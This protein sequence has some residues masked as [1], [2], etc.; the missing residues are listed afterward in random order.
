MIEPTEVL[1]G[2]I[3]AIPSKSYTHRAI[4]AASLSEGESRITSPLYAD[5]TLVTIRACETFGV[6]I[7][8]SERKLIVTGLSQLKTPSS[9]IDCGESAS[10]I[11]FLT[12][13]AA[14]VKGKTVL[15]GSEG[16]RRRPIA[17]LISALEKLGVK[18]SSNSGFPPVTVFGGGLKGGKTSLVGDV[19]SQFITGLLLACP[20]ARADSEIYLT[21][22]LESKPYV[23][24]TLAMLKKHGVEINASKSLRRYAVRGGQSYRSVDHNVPGDFSA[25]SFLLSAAAITKSEITVTGLAMDQPD[26]EIVNILHNMGAIVDVNEYSVKVSGKKLRGVEID[27][28]DIPDLVPIC[29]VLA[30]YSEGETRIFGAKRLRIK[31]S[32]RLNTISTELIKMG[33]RVLEDAEGMT[34]KGSCRLHGAVIN[35]HGDHRIAMACAVAGL[36]AE[37]KTEILEAECVDKSYPGFFKD[38]ARLG[39]QVDV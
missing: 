23:R 22:P 3:H 19:S 4:I 13:L 25:A 12:P 17:P 1:S 35:P 37:G 15:D 18:C 27:A 16:L 28:R 30:C 32:D 29:A 36:K 34:I 21:T 8:Q 26:S 33:G 5:D 6:T 7:T 39:V 2:E 31:E 9:K 24:L 10:S 38:L 14:L 20:L 11:R